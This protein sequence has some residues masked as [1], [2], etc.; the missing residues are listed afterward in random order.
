MYHIFFIHSSVD[1]HLGCFHVLAIMNS[2]AT[3]IVVHVSF[4]I[5]VFSRY[6]PRSGIAPSNGNSIFIFWGNLHNVLYSGFT[7][8]HSQHVEG[9]LFLHILSIYYLWTLWWWPFM[10]VMRWYLIVVLILIS[11]IINDVKHLFMC[12]LAICMSS[13]EKCLF[14]SSAQ[15]HLFF[16]GAIYGHIKMLTCSFFVNKINTLMCNCFLFFE[17]QVKSDISQEFPLWLSGKNRSPWRCMFD[18]GLTQ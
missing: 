2:A 16:G 5:R 13:L 4:R 9:L 18:P 6:M 10:T 15:Y 7:N 12:L 8:L 17:A 14:R 1:G 3:N 11:L